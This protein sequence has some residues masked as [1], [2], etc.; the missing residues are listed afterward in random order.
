MQHPR[1]GKPE[2]RRMRV[3][4]E[5]T[6]PWTWY[7]RI[8]PNSCSLVILLKVNPAFGDEPKIVCEGCYETEDISILAQFSLLDVGHYR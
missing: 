5:V 4:F 8:S 3:R 7:Y 6:P 1:D 2:F